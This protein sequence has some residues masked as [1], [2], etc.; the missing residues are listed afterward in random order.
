LVRA[1]EQWVCPRS[2]AWADSVERR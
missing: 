1:A 2:V